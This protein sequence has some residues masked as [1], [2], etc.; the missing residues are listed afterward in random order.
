MVPIIWTPIPVYSIKMP[1]DTSLHVSADRYNIYNNNNLSLFIPSH[2]FCFESEKFSVH[3]HF[4]SFLHLQ[5]A[6]K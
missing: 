1:L 4:V 3:I 5:V 6:S 2:L